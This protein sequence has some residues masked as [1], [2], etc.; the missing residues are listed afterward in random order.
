MIIGGWAHNELLRDNYRPRGWKWVKMSK[1]EVKAYDN[2]PNISA[3]FA[4]DTENSSDDS[5]YPDDIDKFKYNEDGHA[6]VCNRWI[7]F[8]IKIFPL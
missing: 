2:D 8:H 1:E 5:N 4:P 6:I 3:I 7:G